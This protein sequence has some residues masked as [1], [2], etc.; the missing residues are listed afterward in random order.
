[1]RT[2]AGRLAAALGTPLA[3]PDGG[4]THRFPTPAQLADADPDLF[5]M[6]RGRARALQALAAA[7]A[8]GK[9]V[10]DPGANRG[11]VCAA[12]VELPGIGP[13][14]AAYVA[15][16][17]LR[18]PDAFMPTDLGVRHALERLGQPGDPRAAEALSQRWRPWRSYAL[19]HLWSAPT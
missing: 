13:W 8:D 3:T 9:L 4:L 7:L 2:I 10:L 18:D 19:H 16:R 11:E 14:T 15:L 12:L 1:A 17:A 5:P 6:P